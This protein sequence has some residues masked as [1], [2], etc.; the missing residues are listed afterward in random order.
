M[1]DQKRLKEVTHFTFSAKQDSDEKSDVRGNVDD[2]DDEEDNRVHEEIKTANIKRFALV[3]TTSESSE[4]AHTHD[5][6]RDE[7]APSDRRGSC[8]ESLPHS[9]IRE[10]SCV[11]LSVTSEI[12]PSLSTRVDEVPPE[13]TLGL[14][15]KFS[16][17]NAEQDFLKSLSSHD[18]RKEELKD[19]LQAFSTFPNHTVSS[20]IGN[21]NMEVSVLKPIHDNAPDNKVT[22]VHPQRVLQKRKNPLAELYYRGINRRKNLEENLKAIREAQVK[23]LENCTFQPIITKRGRSVRHSSSHSGYYRHNTHLRQRLLL[24]TWRSERN[25]Q[26]RPIPVISKGS[27]NIVRRV[28]GG[29][30][31]VIPASERLYMDSARRRCR[32]EEEEEKPKKPV[33]VR[34]LDDVKAHVDGLYLSEEKRKLALQ[35]LRDEMEKNTY[36]TPLHVNS[37]DVVNR[38]T[39]GKPKS[40]CYHLE[41][42]DDVRFKPKLSSTTKV[43]SVCARKRRLE[44]WY[45]F[46]C[47]Y[48]NSKELPQ[49]AIFEKIRDALQ[50]ETFPD[51]LSLDV[52]CIALD[53]YEETH[54]TQLWHSILPP[55]EPHL[56]EE[57]TFVPKVNPYKRKESSSSIHQRLFQVA[58][59]RQMASKKKDQMQREAEFLAEEKRRKKLQL[60]SAQNSK[61]KEKTR[62]VGVEMSH[63]T[64]LRRELTQNADFSSGVGSSSL[65]QVSSSSSLE[66]MEPIFASELVPEKCALLNLLNAADDLRNLIDEPNEIDIHFSPSPSSN[67]NGLQTEVNPQSHSFTSTVE[68]EMEVETDSAVPPVLPCKQQKPK[69]LTDMQV[70]TDILLECAL[71]RRTWSADVSTR[72][73]EQCENR[74]RL[75]EVGKTLYQR[76]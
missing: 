30:A 6:K 56:N 51:G 23:E 21:E 73:R 69:R 18:I 25:E 74:R 68:I 4:L 71:S 31:P 15:E 7:P 12:V 52:F 36:Q 13:S 22:S 38:L 20:E 8:N 44:K 35:K 57:L 14:M 28:R 76:M 48:Q 70:S 59:T 47:Q 58:K 63:T 2:Y 34:T 26:C 53:K 66:H 3:D 75:K 33:V 49:C 62:S 24:E 39:Q 37:K 61:V 27:E 32:I 54:G 60:W 46:W 11:S 43:L 40:K 72:R 16:S 55:S 17:L 42:E 64:S 67:L 19:I 9:F 65:S 41:N 10:S 29:S 50:G 45:R 5:E 1:S